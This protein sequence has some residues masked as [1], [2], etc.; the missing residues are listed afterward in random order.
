M[1]LEHA[2]WKKV[3]NHLISRL[4]FK[5]CLQIFKEAA[6]EPGLTLSHRNC[7]V[8]EAHWI[9]VREVKCYLAHSIRCVH[10]IYFS[11]LSRKSSGTDD[12]KFMGFCQSAWYW[13]CFRCRKSCFG[14]FE[15]F[16]HEIW[17]TSLYI[18]KPCKDKWNVCLLLIDLF[19]RFSVKI[20]FFCSNHV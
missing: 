12:V 2:L 13:H 11:I 8:Y 20:S 16:S 9:I 15:E 5:K 3:M 19:Y 17:Q 4:R 1:W 6:P 10:L 18:Q 7:L 14:P